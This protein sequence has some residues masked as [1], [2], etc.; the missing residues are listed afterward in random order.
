M[1]DTEE[2][3]QKF[4]VGND[5]LKQ[6][7]Q[8]LVTKALQHCVVGENGTV[9]I[10]SNSVGAKDKIKLV[11][12]ARRLAAQLTGDIKGDVTV[13]ELSASTG[14]PENQIRARANEIVKERFATS[15]SRGV[16]NANP[17]K[18]EPFLDGLSKATVTAAPN[19]NV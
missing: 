19:T 11:L 9:H 2:L 6:R 8:V 14:L 13:S 4:I 1:M 12:S 7:L 5:V 16:Y 15:P 10:N 18:V 3:K 17:H